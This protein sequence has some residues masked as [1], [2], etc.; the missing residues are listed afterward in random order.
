MS[1]RP[2][3]RMNPS[4][5]PLRDANRS[6]T[7]PISGIEVHDSIQ[8]RRVDEISKM[9]LFH[10]SRTS[11]SAVWSGPTTVRREA[12]HRGGTTGSLNARGTT[13]KR[14]GWARRV[15]VVA[16]LFLSASPR[17][18]EK[19]RCAFL[20]SAVP[21]ASDGDVDRWTWIPAKILREDKWES[22]L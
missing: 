15:G 2:P 7:L 17:P 20:S 1:H 3:L 9:N 10:M 4:S 12:H 13:R 8:T 21:F 19:T 22:V 5:K 14:S 6:G 11:R 18:A 16:S